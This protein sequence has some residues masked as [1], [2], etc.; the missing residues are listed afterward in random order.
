MILALFA[1]LSAHQT[2]VQTDVVY[3]HAGGVDQKMDLYTPTSPL[4]KPMAAVVVIHGGAWIGGQRSDMAGVAVTLQ[5]QG[6]FVANVEYRVAPKSIWPAMLDDVQTA[7][8]YLRAN[9]SKYN[10]DPKRIGACGM[11]AGGHLSMFL[12]CADTRDTKATEY[13][14][15]SSRVSAVLNFSGPCDMSKPFAPVLD[16][17]FK[18]VLG[19]DKKDA[20]EEI[21]SASPINFV[22]KKSAPMFIYQGLADPLVNPDQAREAEAKY[23]TVGVPCDMRLLEGVKHEINVVDPKAKQAIDDGIAWLKKFLA[24]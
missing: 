14:D 11:S 9:A 18:M 2:G 22:D 7:V 24:G 5:Q 21:K 13:A 20:A 10:I 4:R 3:S 23:K 8:R 1:I 16:P 12:G 6:F 19:K 15:Q 17:I